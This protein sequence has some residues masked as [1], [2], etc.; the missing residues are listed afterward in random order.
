MASLFTGVQRLDQN[1]LCSARHSQCVRFCGFHQL[2]SV[3]L[4]FFSGSVSSGWGLLSVDDDDGVEEDID[5]ADG[6]DED[7]GGEADENEEEEEEGF[8]ARSR[9]S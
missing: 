1:S 4:V 7:E 5:I 8:S 2:G 9:K 3:L 6:D